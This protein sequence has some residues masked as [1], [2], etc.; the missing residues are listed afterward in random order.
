MTNQNDVTSNSEVK[1]SKSKI[2]IEKDEEYWSKKL[3]EAIHAS[4]VNGED[5][6]HEYVNVSEFDFKIEN[7]CKIC[8]FKEPVSTY[9]SLGWD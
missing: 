1:K 4:F 2:E 3:V 7:K 6:K 8:G 5:H 9:T